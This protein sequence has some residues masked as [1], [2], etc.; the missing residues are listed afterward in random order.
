MYYYKAPLP[1]LDEIEE[2]LK[3]GILD[4]MILK[5]LTERELYG[6][7]IKQLIFER[8][9]QTILI[10]EGSLYGPLYRMGK[11]EFITSRKELVGKKRF[12][13]YYSIT[14]LGRTYLKTAEVA[15][16]QLTAGACAIILDENKKRY[17][18]YE[19]PFFLFFN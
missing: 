7:E 12:R 1:F 5:L 16:K 3:V 17:F 10:K 4:I 9:N 6:Y 2:N 15:Y 19:I 8:S 18:T 14:E 11:K 13:M